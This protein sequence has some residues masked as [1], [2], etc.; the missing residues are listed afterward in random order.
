VGTESTAIAVEGL[1]KRY[2]D[3][4]GR[5]RVR[6]LE[7][8]DLLVERGASF[9][10]LGP[11]GSGK[12]TTMK[13]LLGLIRPTAGTVRVLGHPAGDLR[14][15]ARTGF[16]PEESYLHPFLTGHETLDLTGRLFRIPRAERLRRA[17][18]LLERVGLASEAARRPVRTYSRGMA[19]R[20]GL[21]SA[22][23]NRPDL[24]LLDE[25][26]AGLD[27]LVA[28]SVKELIREVSEGGCSVLL[29]SHLLGDVESLCES[30]TMLDRGRI[31]ASGAVRDLVEEP[32][33]LEVRLES[34]PDD[35]RDRLERAL[36]GSGARVA[37]ARPP[38][39]R[40]E[41]LFRDLIGRDR[42]S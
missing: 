9:G 40:L 8:I 38:R 26:T 23:L 4:W 5:A 35:V 28:A 30:V 19:R 32:D 1:V 29:S 18:E 31:V 21:A 27:P 41:D 3:F 15:R 11:N 7:G 14:A 17:A 37:S 42:S 12:T 13:T 16:L 33:A 10:L 39:R 24:L 34:P 6:A 22:L 20:L 2:R 25:P 36:E